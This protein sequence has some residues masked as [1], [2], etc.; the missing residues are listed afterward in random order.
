[1]GNYN[2]GLLT[3]EKLINSARKL[4]YEYGYIKTTIKAICE[5]AGILRTGFVYYFKHKAAIADYVSNYVNT[6]VFVEIKNELHARGQK[7]DALLM[8]VYSS[9]LFF[10]SIM[11]DPHLNLFYSEILTNNADMLLGDKFYRTLFQNMYT[12]C[13]KDINSKE[14]ELFFIY[15]TSSP[16]V[17]LKRY[18]KGS[19]DLTKEEIVEYFNR[20]IMRGLSIE[21]AE[22]NKILAEVEQLRNEIKIDL[23]DLFLRPYEHSESNNGDF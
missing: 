20:E 14:F 6:Q 9:S 13:G 16:G 5:D 11:S 10:L 8:F 23:Q 15:N 19:V 2:A 21:T 1:M 12:A 4:F 3:Q 7:L 18:L 17:F 22:Q